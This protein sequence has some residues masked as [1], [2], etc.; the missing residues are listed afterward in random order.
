[1]T[2]R[3][4][5]IVAMLAAAAAAAA[6]A[7]AAARRSGMPRAWERY[8][9][10]VEREAR[11]LFLAWTPARFA[12]LHAGG[13]VAT[14]G[15]SAAL[16]GWALGVLAG[17]SAAWAGFGWF[18]RI[19]RRR[20]ARLEA[21]LDPTLRSMAQTLRVT[22]NLADAL[23]T[24]AQQIEAPMA[25]E[26]DLCLRQHRLGLSIEDALRL[27]GDRAGGQSLGTV[28]TAV[29]LAR[30]TGGDLPRILDEVATT[31]RER[32]RLDG[33]IEAKTAEGRAQAWVMGMVPPALGAMLWHLD[34]DLLRPL[35]VDPVGWAI[36]GTVGV[37]EALGVW[38]VRRVTSI[39]V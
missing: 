39:E 25:E 30:T 1:M 18:R 16:G 14:A 28:A 36:L 38:G 37:L 19:R 9:E 15:I 22:A 21:Q 35:F 26:M 12:L 13:A 11:E 29:V 34:P 20:R 33:L 8:A 4:V 10:W 27:M 23:E 2:P 5:E 32:V 3:L 31:L 24:V 17:A 7:A 6:W